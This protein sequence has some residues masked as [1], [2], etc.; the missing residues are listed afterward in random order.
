[1]GKTHNELDLRIA[2]LIRLLAAIGKQSHET[3]QLLAIVVITLCKE[4]VTF[5]G[6]PVTITFKNP[7]NQEA[8]F[9]ITNN[10]ESAN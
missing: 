2:H 6:P 5:S 10:K 8:T 9:K 7:G 1:M 3:M 4:G